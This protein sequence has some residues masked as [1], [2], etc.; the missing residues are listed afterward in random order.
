MFAIF[1]STFPILDISSP[2]LLAY[3]TFPLLGI[4]I[5]SM[6][7]DQLGTHPFLALSICLDVIVKMNLYSA[8]SCKVS[9]LHSKTPSLTAGSRSSTGN[10]FQTVGPRQRRL[11][12]RVC[13][14]DT[15]EHQAVQVGWS[16]MSTGNV[17]D[18]SAAVC[19][20]DTDGPRQPAC[21]P[22]VQERWASG[23]GRESAL[24]DHSRACSELDASI[25][26][27]FTV[28]VTRA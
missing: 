15:A 22:R 6:T 26:W 1:C 18:R 24:I 21:T 17:G 19:S 4:C 14:V 9:Q 2:W 27:R 7:I 13:Y 5:Q 23:V 28:A 11:A 12:D 10:E 20:P 3:S 16:S 8:V 25:S